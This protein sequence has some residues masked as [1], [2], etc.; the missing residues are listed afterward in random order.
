MTEASVKHTRFVI[1][2][3]RTKNV[4]K[5]LELISVLVMIIF[6]SSLL[7]TLL[8]RYVYTDPT[9]ME[10]PAI[11]EVIPVFSFVLGAAMFIYVVV[12]NLM[13]EMRAMKLEK[14]LEMDSMPMSMSSSAM[15]S[16]T[17][18]DSDDLQAAMKSLSSKSDTKRRTK[19]VAAQRVSTRSTKRSA[20]RKNK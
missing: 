7:P 15:D 11:F 19:V 9:M 2:Q 4:W 17:S 16:R 13:R 14:A 12:S 8:L 20:K 10:T 3:L 6:V 18:N 5:E 1:N